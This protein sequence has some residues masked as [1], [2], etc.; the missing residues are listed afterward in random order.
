MEDD[1][2][3]VSVELREVLATILLTIIGISTNFS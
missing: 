3:T 1:Y 2:R